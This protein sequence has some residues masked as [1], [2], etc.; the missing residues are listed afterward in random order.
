V[1]SV[2]FLKISWKDVCLNHLLPNV[3][4]QMDVLRK[5]LEFFNRNYRGCEKFEMGQAHLPV[6]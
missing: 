1:F 5:S 2:L 6:L 4:Q 3:F